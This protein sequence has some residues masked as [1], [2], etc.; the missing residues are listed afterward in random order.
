MDG[1]TGLAGDDDEPDQE[2]EDELETVAP[3]GVELELELG[4]LCGHG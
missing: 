3:A 2:L 1:V 4:Q